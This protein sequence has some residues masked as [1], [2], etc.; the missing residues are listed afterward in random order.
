VI[1]IFEELRRAGHDLSLVSSGATGS[2][3]I[4]AVP[5][6]AVPF[7]PLAIKRLADAHPAV[8]VSVVEGVE[9]ELLDRLRKRDIEL[10]IIRLSLLDP[11]GDLQMSTLSEETLCVV[12]DKDHR[13]VGRKNLSWPELRGERWVMPPPE[14]YFFEHVQRTLRDLGL[15]LPRPTV[16]SFSRHIQ[17][18]MVMH[19]GMLS[20]AL[21]PP[22]NFSDAKNPV[23]KL[24]F[25]MPSNIR[26]IGA[27][28]LG[29]RVQS[30]LAQQL[31]GHMQGLVAV[32]Y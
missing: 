24:D 23:V 18:G 2:L 4:G 30:P 16:E 31:V 29:S 1:A 22:G 10:A 26:A 15:E 5:M 14:G 12:A 13:L 19:G 8:F 21:R 3:R 25:E 32:A 28:W 20:F 9:A 27:V 7:L 6:P 17:F 11:E